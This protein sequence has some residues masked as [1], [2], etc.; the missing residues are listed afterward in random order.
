M[1]KH[2]FPLHR[3]QVMY[4]FPVMAFRVLSPKFASA[5]SSHYDTGKDV[6]ERLLRPIFY[7]AAAVDHFCSGAHL[8]PGEC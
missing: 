1:Y 2:K 5:W 6:R 7:V 4:C 8:Q 3:Y